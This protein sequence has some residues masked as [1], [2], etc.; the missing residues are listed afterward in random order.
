MTTASRRSAA[1]V[2]DEMLTKPQP[3]APFP[4]IHTA[5]PLTLADAQQLQAVTE[6]RD[7]LEALLQDSAYWASHTARNDCFATRDHRTSLRSQVIA[8]DR[9][10]YAL[11]NPGAPSLQEQ[12]HAY[13]AAKEAEGKAAKKDPSWLEL[14]GASIAVTV[15][16]VGLLAGLAGGM[17][18]LIHVAENNPF[19]TIPAQEYQR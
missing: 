15:G 9:R 14:I 16:Y 13:A 18:L 1:Q 12:A 7:D 17:A 19:S 8:L 10:I 4:L 2:I 5:G 3:V 11:Q 6:Q